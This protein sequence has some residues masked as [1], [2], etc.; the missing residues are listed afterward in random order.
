MNT[1]NFVAGD[2]PFS[3]NTRNFVAG[4]L[5][6]IS[7]KFGSKFKSQFSNTIPMTMSNIK[8]V[9]KLQNVRTTKILSVR[10]LKIQT[11]L[12]FLVFEHCDLN[13][14]PNFFDPK[15]RSHCSN[16]RIFEQ[17]RIFNDRE[18]PKFRLFEHFGIRSQS[19]KISNFSSEQK[20]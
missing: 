15:F 13:F 20:N 19:L 12:K 14:E 9:K 5:N 11:C 6:L 17:V 7:K 3:M 10:T 8:I 1:R 16:T 18:H 2:S 4:D